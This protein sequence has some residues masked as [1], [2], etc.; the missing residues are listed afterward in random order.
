M[1]GQITDPDNDIAVSIVSLWEIAIKLP[2]RRGTEWDIEL[3]VEQAMAEFDAAQFDVIGIG[4]RH[5]SVIETLPPHHGDPFDRLLV[6][7]AYAD[8]YRLVTHDRQL[9]KYGDQIILI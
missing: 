8:T 6:A 7:T 9:M 5:L 3:T 4:V 1:A 2:L